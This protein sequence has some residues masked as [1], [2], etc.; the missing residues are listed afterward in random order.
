MSHSCGNWKCLLR[1]QWKKIRTYCIKKVKVVEWIETMNVK[2]QCVALLMTMKT[3]LSCQKL[4]QEKNE[5]KH[6]NLSNASPVTLYWRWDYQSTFFP[7]NSPF[8]HPFLTENG[9]VSQVCI[10]AKKKRLKKRLLYL[11]LSS[12]W[13][14][15]V[16]HGEEKRKKVV[17]REKKQALCNRLMN[18]TPSFLPKSQKAVRERDANQSLTTWK[19]RIAA[20]IWRKMCNLQENKK[21]SEKTGAWILIGGLCFQKVSPLCT[22]VQ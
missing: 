16:V 9:I 17:L 14:T 5:T 8:L 11:L 13:K 18:S 20:A 4:K 6:L 15:K 19:I 3:C 7:V 1:F 22:C 10:C 12:L 2:P 21:S